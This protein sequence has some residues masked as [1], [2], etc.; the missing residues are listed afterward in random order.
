[1]DPRLLTGLE[2]KVYASAFGWQIGWSRDG[3]LAKWSAELAV[4]RLR[5]QLAELDAKELPPEEPLGG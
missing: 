3:D 1:M 2:Q 4:I 5:E